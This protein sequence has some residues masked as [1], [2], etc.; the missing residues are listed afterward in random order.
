MK[1]KKSIRVVVAVASVALLWWTVMF[2]IV[3]R[4]LFDVPYSTLLYSRDS[5]LLGARIASDGQWRFPAS[6]SVPARFEAALLTYEDKRFYSHPGIDPLAVARA[7]KLNMSGGRVVSGGSTV[8]MQLARQ[9]RGRRDRNLWQK[10]VEAMY[11]LFIEC[12]H[13][14]SEIL[15]MY[16]S[17]APFGGNV[18]G[19]EAASWRYFGRPADELSWAENAVLAVLPNSPSL[20]HPGRNRLA[21]KHKRDR[22]LDRMEQRGVIDATECSLAKQEP[23]PDAPLSLPDGAPHLLERLAVERRGERMVSSL[24]GRLQ[25]LVSAMVDRYGALYASSNRVFNAAA[26]VA[27]VETGEVLAYAGNVTGSS[28]GGAVDIITSERSSGS[29]LKPLL[30]AGM[31][32]DGLILPG[33]LVADTPLKIGGFAPQNYNR[34][35]Y[36]AVPA[37]QAVT[38]SLNVPLVRMLSKYNTGRFM[39]LLD[40]LGMSTLHYPEGH[41]GASIILG[42]AEC[43]LWDVCGIY[44]SLARILAHFSAYDCRYDSGDIHPLTPFVSGS[45]RLDPLDGWLTGEAPVLSAAA[46]WFAF[47]AMSELGRPE[48]EAEW[49]QFASMKRVAWKTGTSYGGRDAWAVGLTPRYVVGV[50]VGNA[51]GEGRPGLTGVSYAGPLLF[52]IFS[53]LDGGEWFDE[54]LCEMETAEI[55]PVSGHKASP[56]CPVTDSVTIP[57]SGINTTPC[58]YHRRVHLSSDGRW[59]VDSSCESIDRMVSASWFVLPPAQEYYYRQYHADYRPL[60]PLGPGCAQETERRMDIIYPEHGDMITLPRGFDGVG[61]TMVMQAAHVLPD[62]TVYWY[63][64]DEF[65]GATVGTHEM[66]AAPEPGEHLLSLTDSRGNRRKIVFTV[67]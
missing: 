67:R 53:L 42:G 39:E 60:P 9:A 32:H 56:L 5:M 66:T 11:A 44:A 27:D 51:S 63:I 40:T 43:T 34:R 59:R 28:H 65:I 46:L 41:Y 64:D 62:E 49:Q 8:T 1:F 45:G 50:W 38:Q 26:L 36:G 12:T 54:P 47:E 31:L 57:R 19:L 7:V 6:D 61:E 48:E 16:V 21:L 20:I 10:A 35:Y 24:D 25:R 15:A 55:C 14:K 33:T 3:P 4:P 58:P 18:V 23:L 29:I 22:L 52:D 30:Y 13:S 17:H 2:C 37:R